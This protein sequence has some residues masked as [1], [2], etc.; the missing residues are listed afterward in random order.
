MAGL[1]IPKIETKYL[2][3]KMEKN[4][5][6]R[7]STVNN[8]TNFQRQ[9]KEHDWMATNHQEEGREMVKKTGKQ[10]KR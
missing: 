6:S 10:R 8:G 2:I 1:A 9:W 7:D 3:L 4:V 5:S